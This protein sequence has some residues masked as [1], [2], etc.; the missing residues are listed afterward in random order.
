MKV[1]IAGFRGQLGT[2]LLATAPQG[3][4]VSAMDLPELDITSQASVESA[5]RDFCADVIINAAAYTAVDKA[6][7]EEDLAYSVNCTGVRNLAHAARDCGAR[8]VHIST[9]YVFDGTSCR[10]YL[11]TDNTSPVSAYG[12]TKLAGELA[13]SG[14]LDNYAIIRTSW[15]Y[16]AHG[17]NFVKTMLRLMGERKSL[18]VVADQIGTP[19][20]AKTLA[21]AVWAAALN[22]S[23]CGTYHWSDAGVASWYDFAYNVMLLGVETGLLEREIEIKPIRTADYPTPAKR[24]CYSMLD[25]TDSYRDFAMPAEH[26]TEPLREI[27]YE[28]KENG[29]AV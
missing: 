1:F 17:A 20:S 22:E 4:E 27:I 10:P 29:N 12:R 9:D 13:V 28:I 24:P 5:V 16:S 18:G 14:E 6:E 23:A 15:L 3:A 2:E 21:K 7:S 8:F 26:W 25:K 19:T 11:P